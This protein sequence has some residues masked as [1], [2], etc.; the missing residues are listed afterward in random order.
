MTE[1]ENYSS[2]YYILAD[3]DILPYN[4]DNVAVDDELY[5]YLL[6]YVRSP[7]A[8]VNGGHYKIQPEWGVPPHTVALPDTWNAHDRD[9]LLIAKRRETMDVL[10]SDGLSG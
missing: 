3:T 9:H 8:K 7:I 4:G 10:M 1:L 2:R 6:E 5:E